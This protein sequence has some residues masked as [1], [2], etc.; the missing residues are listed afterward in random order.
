M[1]FLYM[2]LAMKSINTTFFPYRFIGGSALP[3]D[4]SP[5]F[6]HNI[7]IRMQIGGKYEEL[8][9]ALGFLILTNYL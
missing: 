2:L 9:Q 4:L 7:S 8:V 1:V 3:I 5:S 6:L